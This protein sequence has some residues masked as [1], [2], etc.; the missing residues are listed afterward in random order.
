MIRI[1]LL[2]LPEQPASAS[3]P[4]ISL[5]KPAEI[6]AVAIV[7]LAVVFVGF[8][9]YSLSSQITTLNADIKQADEELKELQDALDL[10][11]VHKTRKAQLATRVELISNL[12]RR[13][14]VPVHLAGLHPIQPVFLLCS[15]EL[16]SQIGSRG[17]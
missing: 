13:Q 16:L 3:K 7:L 11:E 5:G 6:G 17:R 12:K 1:N 14:Q 4:K 10:I 8:R 2:E 9:W 15:C